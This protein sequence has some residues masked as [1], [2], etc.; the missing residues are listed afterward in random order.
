LQGFGLAC[1]QEVLGNGIGFLS[2]DK[3]V[4]LFREIHEGRAPSSKVLVMPGC[5]HSFL[6]KSCKVAAEV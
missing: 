3:A 5:L 4:D 6:A 1:F 2:V